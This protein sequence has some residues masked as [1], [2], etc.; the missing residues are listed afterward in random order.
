MSLLKIAVEKLPPS[1]RSSLEKIHHCCVLSILKKF[2][3]NLL[4]V[5]VCFLERQRSPL[6]SI[7]HNIQNIVSLSFCDSSTWQCHLCSFL[8]ARSRVLGNNSVVHV[9]MVNA[10]MLLFMFLTICVCVC[11]RES[12]DITETYSFSITCAFYHLTIK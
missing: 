8:N 7:S 5:L 3:F 11:D 4:C 2:I 6:S 9:L 1:Q 10:L 12:L